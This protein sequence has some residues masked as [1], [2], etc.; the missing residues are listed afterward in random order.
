MAQPQIQ[1]KPYT[2]T[3]SE[4]AVSSRKFRICYNNVDAGVLFQKSTI[5][6]KLRIGY[7]PLFSAAYLSPSLP[8][9]APNVEVEH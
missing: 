2:L 8:S 6:G 5:V 3:L 9:V 1:R 4:A 7:Q